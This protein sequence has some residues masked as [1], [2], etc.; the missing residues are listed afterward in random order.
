[1]PPLNLVGDYGGGSLYLVAGLLAALLSA[2]RTGEGQVV[3][4]AM[5]DGAASLMAMFSECRRRAA[6][7]DGAAPTCS[8]AARPFIAPTPA[9]TGRHIALG[10]LEPQFYALFRKLV[11]LADDPD[12]D[13]RDD[14]DVWPTLRAPSWRRCSSPARATNGAACSKGPTPASR[15]C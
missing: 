13:R 8:T 15:R 12:F 1:M 11:G 2:A 9:R 4:C 6:G 7:R 5:T 14:P 10:P 3:D